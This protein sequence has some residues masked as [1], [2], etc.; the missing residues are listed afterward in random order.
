[1]KNYKQFITEASGNDEDDYDEY[2][3]QMARTQLMSIAEKAAELAKDV[4]DDTQLEALVE[5]KITL[6]EDYIQTV[7]DYLRYNKKE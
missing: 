3:G 2:R 5:S 1:M 7:Y 6:A 4:K